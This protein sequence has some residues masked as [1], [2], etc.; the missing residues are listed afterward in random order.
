[1]TLQ[2]DFAVTG[3][4][5]VGALRTQRTVRCNNGIQGHTQHTSSVTGISP[6]LVKAAGRS[7]EIGHGTRHDASA[8]DRGGRL[9]PRFLRGPRGNRALRTCSPRCASDAQPVQRVRPT[10]ICCSILTSSRVRRRMQ[11]SASLGRSTPY[12]GF[13]EVCLSIG[14]SSMCEPWRSD[15]FPT[16]LRRQYRPIHVMR[17][18]GVASLVER[19]LER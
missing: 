4:S 14:H 18:G 19:G 5:V 12:G 8:M 2:A 7:T 6:R 9:A 17:T 1:M 10:S 15:W 16:L 13:Y 11:W 3:L